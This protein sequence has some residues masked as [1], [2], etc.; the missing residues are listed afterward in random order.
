MSAYEASYR[1]QHDSGV[2]D[3]YAHWFLSVL[4]LAECMARYAIHLFGIVAVSVLYYV[5]VCISCGKNK[6]SLRA[7][8]DSQFRLFGLY[9]G[10]SCGVFWNIGMICMNA[11]DLF[12]IIFILL[13]GYSLCLFLVCSTSLGP[14]N[15]C[16]SC[17]QFDE[18]WNKLCFINRDTH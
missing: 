11:S 3:L 8:V 7:V 13:P 10:L 17:D 2:L 14:S 4:A 12:S 16:L 9:W 1:K 6:V 5:F 18:V 15:V